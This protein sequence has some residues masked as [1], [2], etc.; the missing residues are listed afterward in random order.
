MPKVLRIL[1]KPLL[2]LAALCGIYL[3]LGGLLLPV[4]LQRMAEN[5]VAESGHRLTMERPRFNPVLLRLTANDLSLNEADG[6]P[7]LAFRELVVDLSLAS[8]FKRALVF[9]EIRLD[10]LEAHIVALPEERFNWSA[11]IDALHEETPDETAPSLPRLIINRFALT[12]GSLH[13]VDRRGAVERATR[14]TPL[15]LELAELSTLPNDKG[16]YEL[17]TKTS[18]GAQLHWQGELSLN[19]LALQG[20][21]TIDALALSRLAELVPLPAALAPPEGDLSVRAEYRI[22]QPDDPSRHDM[23]DIVLHPFSATLKDLRLQASNAPEPLLAA[24]VLELQGGRFNLLQRRVDAESLTVSGGNLLLQWLPDGQL[25]LVKLV[26]TLAPDWKAASA[27]QTGNWHYGIAQVR[28]TGLNARLRD[29]GVRPAAEFALQDIT[30]RI[31]NLSDNLSVPLPLEIALHSNDD[32]LFNATGTVTPEPLAATLTVRFDGIALMPAQPYV[33]RVAALRLTDGR[34]SG[35]GELRYEAEDLRYRGSLALHRLRLL[36]A[37]S[38]QVFLAWKS[39]EAPSL[40]FDPHRLEARELLLHGLSSR[41]IIH[42]DKTVNLSQILHSAPAANP[43]GKKTPEFRA[44]IGRLRIGDGIRFEFADYSLALPFATQIHALRGTITGISTRRNAPPA[45]VKLEGRV[46]T[47]GMMQA[48]GKIDLFEPTRNMDLNAQFRNVEM[49]QL[50][51]YTATFAGRRIES[52][53]L[54]LDLEYRIADRQLQGNNRVIMDHLVLGEQVESAEAWNLPL[55]LAIALLEDSNGR[56]DLGLPVSGNLDDPQ[57]SYG[58]LVWKAI[59]NV[60][61]RIATAPFRAL[62]ALFGGGED[63]DGITFEAGRARLNPPER[64]KLVRFAEALDKRPHLS[65]T[66][67]GVWSEADRVALQDLQLRR[68]LA[69]KLGF[70]TKGDPGDL[71]LAQPEGKSAIERLIVDRFGRGELASL[72][73][74]FQAANPDRPLATD[75]GDRLLSSLAGLLGNKRALAPEE[76]E[77]MRGADFHEILYRRLLQSET[78]PDT[79][80][81]T[82]AQT[83]LDAVIAAL[84]EANA[85]MERIR[86][87]K[88]DKGSADENGLIP[89]NIALQP[90]EKEE[91]SNTGNQTSAP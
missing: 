16:L 80:L 35:E 56:I 70:S 58:Q 64:E 43:P 30:A 27:L 44:D 65:A 53:K 17:T 88:E 45:Q 90:I 85:P 55:D 52:G 14:L 47:Y 31:D 62:G 11:L 86:T 21:F 13:L 69:G 39:L 59:T 18:L 5:T 9:D 26:S 51:P 33:A 6:K 82:L 7:L 50:T 77:A 20:Y 29:Q 61:T 73:D 34:L 49:T 83:R 4:L 2:I 60:L 41:L 74:G 89:F 36:E 37:G 8:L 78:V 46:D 32:G 42:Q 23:L 68:A 19:P 71:P 81:I 48:T 66:L 63:F 84:K 57:F 1:K 75:V 25:D 76:I 28:L 22:A 87:G 15:N 10:G 91:A 3:L 67:S 40:N 12:G 72:H 24:D 79:A 38:P 54:S